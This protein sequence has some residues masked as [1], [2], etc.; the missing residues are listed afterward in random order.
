MTEKIDSDFQVCIDSY[1][2]HIKSDYCGFNKNETEVGARMRDEFIT[3]MSLDIGS[4]YIKVITRGSVH[5]FIVLKDGGKWRK[6]DILKPASWKTPAT[7]FSRGNVI[8][9]KYQQR[10]TWT[11]AH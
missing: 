8:T 4:K 11:G 1:L 7:N 10:V 9:G 2:D 3:G 5:S 6:G